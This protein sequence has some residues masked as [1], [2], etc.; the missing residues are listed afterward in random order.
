MKHVINL[1]VSQP[2]HE[3]VSM[4]S[5]TQQKTYLQEARDADEAINRATRHFRTLGFKVHSAVVSEQKQPEVKV[6]SAP[7]ALS[8]S[9][10]GVM[11]AQS[12]QEV[13]KKKAQAE[14]DKSEV[15][16]KAG[17][18]QAGSALAQ[19]LK[20]KASTMKEEVEVASEYLEEKLTAADPASKWIHDFVHSDNP[21]FEG[22]SKKERINMALGAKYAADRAVKEEVEINEAKSAEDWHQKIDNADTAEDMKRIISKVPTK[23][24]QYLHHWNMG[25]SGARQ[26]PA[27]SHIKAELKSRDALLSSAES[28]KRFDEEVELDEGRAMEYKMSRSTIAGD[29]GKSRGGEITVPQKDREEIA[30]I[31]G[32]KDDKK[33]DK[34]L[35]ENAELE[36]AVSRKDFKQVAG[37][38]KEIPDAEKRKELAQ[39]HAEIF[40]NQNPRFDR[41]RFYAAAGVNLGEEVEQLDETGAVKKL[42]KSLKNLNLRSKG[43]RALSGSGLTAQ[44]LNLKNKKGEYLKQRDVN[45][46]AGRTLSAGNLEEGSEGTTPTTPKEKELAAKAGDPN[47]ITKK[48]VL[49]A[50]GVKLDEVKGSAK[51]IAT[52]KAEDERLAKKEVKDSKSAKTAQTLID[53]AKSKKNKVIINPTIDQP[54]K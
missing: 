18:A 23:Y 5:R 35:E 17:K 51:D 15:E 42:N 40:A 24:L 8:E 44:E 26:H 36:E 1:V 28:E 31:L 30:R 16:Q 7:Q 47:K 38:I 4:R 41:S 27:S 19:Y 54:Q 50:R 32:A 2:G 29:R 3:F 22:K 34:K 6:E 49:A 20:N 9:A 14:V 48:D 10:L 33:Q 43:A 11:A 21:K 46:A 39:H 12:K 37:I 25:L 45:L 53:L 13:A 52:E